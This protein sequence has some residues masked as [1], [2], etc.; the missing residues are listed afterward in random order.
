MC[1]SASPFTTDVENHVWEPLRLARTAGGRRSEFTTPRVRMVG[2]AVATY[3]A[4]EGLEG[5]VVVGYDARR[6]PAG[7]PKSWRESSVPTGS[8][9]CFPRDRPTPLVAHAIVERDLAGGLAVTASHNPPEYNGV[10]FIPDDARPPSRGDR[11]HRRPTRRPRSASGERT[12]HRPRGR[13]RHPHADAAVELVESITGDVD[14]SGLTVAYDAMHGSGRGTTDALLSSAGASLEGCAVNVIR[15]SA[16][17]A[18]PSPEN[19][20]ELV[21]VVTDDGGQ[22]SGSRTTATPTGSHSSRP[23]AASS[24][25]ISFRR[26]VRLPL[27]GRLGSCGPIGLDDVPDRPRRGPRESVR[28]VPVGFKWVA[29]AMADGDALVGGGVRRLH[30]SGPRPRKTAS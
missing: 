22:S 30:G 13:P 5:P 11:R 24:T 29:E 10:K 9:S 12:R 25:R 8:T 1:T 19:L 2:Q 15:R 26:A 27:G 21:G 4:D 17:R 14:L 6:V 3:L 7:S 18:E 23:N 28:E 20:T 16:A